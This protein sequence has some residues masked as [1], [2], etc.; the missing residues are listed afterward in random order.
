MQ[1]TSSWEPEEVSK[2][3]PPDP[4]HNQLLEPS[5]E[6]DLKLVEL[7]MSLPFPPTQPEE[8][9]VAEEE[10]SEQ[11]H[12]FPNDCLNLLFLNNIKYSKILILSSL[13]LYLALYFACSDPAPHEL[14][15]VALFNWLASV[16]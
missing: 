10:D 14:G 9:E 8:M 3:K 1:F 13:V 2:P 6:M 11:L 16:V 15:G 5:Q 7:R 12:L 4:V